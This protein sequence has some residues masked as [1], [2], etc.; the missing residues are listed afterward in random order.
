MVRICTALKQIIINITIIIETDYG[1]VCHKIG[2]VLLFRP[3]CL[4][5]II[6]MSSIHLHRLEQISEIKTNEQRFR[7]Q[8]QMS[9]RQ[10]LFG[11]VFHWSWCA[12]H[13]SSPHTSPFRSN[14]KFQRFIRKRLVMFSANIQRYSPFFDIFHIHLCLILF[15]ESINYNINI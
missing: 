15:W 11:T 7:I 12:N 2:Y 5:I 3:P 8:N 14:T 1:D 6:D 4:S 9:N 13:S 10:K